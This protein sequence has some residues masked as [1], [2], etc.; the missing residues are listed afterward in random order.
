MKVQ[1]IKRQSP[2]KRRPIQPLSSVLLAGKPTNSNGLTLKRP[3]ANQPAPA[4]VSTPREVVDLTVADPT[5]PKASPPT[6]VDDDFLLEDSPLPQRPPEGR[7]NRLRKVR[8]VHTE[9]GTKSEEANQSNRSVAEASCYVN[10]QSALE[11][12]FEFEYRVQVAS[13]VNAPQWPVISDSSQQ[14]CGYDLGQSATSP[15]KESPKGSEGNP[16]TPFLFENS[17]SSQLGI[18]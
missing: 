16:R 8:D 6:Q 15:A 14:S 2:V 17:I 10:D 1:D 7:L 12:G 18:L 13:P 4:R 3:P 5:P 9:I 11:N